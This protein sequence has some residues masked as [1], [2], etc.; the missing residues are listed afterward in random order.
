[1]FENRQNSTSR[2]GLF[3]VSSNFGE[4]YFWNRQISERDF[5]YRTLIFI[6]TKSTMIYYKC[7]TISTAYFQNENI[8][9]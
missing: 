7:T 9:L 3:L 4:G 6:Q 8:F 5:W 1:M 2:Q